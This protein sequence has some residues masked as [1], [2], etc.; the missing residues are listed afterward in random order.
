MSDLSDA[1]ADALP[2][3]G[4]I[5]PEAPAAGPVERRIPP[6]NA[7]IQPFLEILLCSS[8]PT[9]LAIGGLLR[10]FGWA[11]ADATGS[12]SLRFVLVLSLSDTAVLIALM[13]FL[14]RLHGESS[15]ALWLGHR[16]LGR[17]AVA[18]LLTVPVLF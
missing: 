15:A 3:D 13:V 12:L 18:G 2:P 1:A 7:R 11:A 8:V 16:P 14:L 5:V 4:P 6:R 17:E 9:Q 10:A